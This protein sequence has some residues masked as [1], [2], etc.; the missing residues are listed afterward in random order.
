MHSPAKLTVGCTLECVPKNCPCGLQ[1]KH[2]EER[3]AA[4]W[5]LLQEPVRLLRAA[6]GALQHLPR[7]AWMRLA[8][9]Q[10]HCLGQLSWDLLVGLLASP[11]SNYV[12]TEDDTDVHGRPA[13]PVPTEAVSESGGESIAVRLAAW[14]V[15]R[16][17]PRGRLSREGYIQSEK[18]DGLLCPLSA[19]GRGVRKVLNCRLI[20]CG[21]LTHMHSG[22]QEPGP[23][24]QLNI[25]LGITLPAGMA[26]SHSHG[27]AH[28]AALHESLLLSVRIHLRRDG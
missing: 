16:A 12:V 5:K 3:R 25:A 21:L 18:H 8:A 23:K 7:G 13:H 14:P 6:T 27:G 26:T 15:T 2:G 11:G 19:D 22:L 1:G 24:R 4:D 10:M 20:C 9:L 28:V 17:H